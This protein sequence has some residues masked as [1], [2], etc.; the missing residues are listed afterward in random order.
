MTAAEGSAD[1]ES[2]VENG[3]K[4]ARLEASSDKLQAH[5][6]VQA[7]PSMC[8]GVLTWPLSFTFPTSQIWRSN[9]IIK[10]NI[11]IYFEVAIPL[12]IRNNNISK[13]IIII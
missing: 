13:N 6:Q 5:I 2:E 4:R 10:I 12:G 1:Q 11:D 9:S 7:V 8:L 3:A